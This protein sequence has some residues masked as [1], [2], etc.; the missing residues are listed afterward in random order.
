MYVFTDM[1]TSKSGYILIFML[2]LFFSFFRAAAS[3]KSQY[4]GFVLF[5]HGQF[6]LPSCILYGL[7]A[8]FGWNCTIHVA[9]YLKD[10]TIPS[11]ISKLKKLQQFI[12]YRNNLGTCVVCA[13]DASKSIGL[14]AMV[15]ILSG[16]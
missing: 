15:K 8:C 6:L 1:C 14:R 11:S 4:V 10:G 16:F 12:L 9:L 7:Y 3:F 5:G 2:L 13:F